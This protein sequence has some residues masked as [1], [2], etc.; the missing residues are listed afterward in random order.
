MPPPDPIPEIRPPAPAWGYAWVDGYWDWS[1]VD[2]TW[3]GGYWMP[4]REGVVYVAPRF[5]FVDGRPVYY[6]SY[7]AGPGGRREYGY[8]YRGA[9]PAAWRARPSATPAAWRAE[10]NAAWRSSPGAGT[11]RGPVHNE[12]HGNFQHPG[13]P[14]GGNFQH[15]GQPAGGNFQHPGQPAGGNFQHPGQPGAAAPNPYHPGAQPPMG[16]ANRA[17][18]PP[19]GGARPP[20]PAPRPAAPA[21]RPAP[22]PS[23]PAP[24]GG[25]RK[26]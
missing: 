7:W 20:A 14:A 19:A 17:S 21:P 11:Y 9:P 5:V 26:K 10:H 23:R 8:G 13:Q 24:S 25:G 15:P 12:P 16:A 1:G 4:Q 18:M 6:R 22:A 2:W 3:N